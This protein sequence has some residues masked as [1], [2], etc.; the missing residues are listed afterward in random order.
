MY[1][2]CSATDRPHVPTYWYRS[3]SDSNKNTMFLLVQ[4]RLFLISKVSHLNR[5]GGDEG[6]TGTLPTSEPLGTPLDSPIVL[7]PSGPGDLGGL[8]DLGSGEQLTHVLAPLVGDP[9]W[10][11]ENLL[12]P[13]VYVNHSE[14]VAFQNWTKGRSFMEV[15]CHYLL[16]SGSVPLITFFSNSSLGTAL[17][18]SIPLSIICL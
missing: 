6:T 4:S 9:W 3:T 16:F 2:L 12:H 7:C 15:I 18:A 14:V 13:P 1:L 17:A 8:W 10:E 11:W 5:S